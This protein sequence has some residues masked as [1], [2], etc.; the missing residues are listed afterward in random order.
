M[1]ND[2]LKDLEMHGA[3]R[4]DLEFPSVRKGEANGLLHSPNHLSIL[5]NIQSF[6]FNSESCIKHYFV[7]FYLNLDSDMS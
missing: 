5:E 1:E 4:D 7:Q 3:K 6:F 2:E